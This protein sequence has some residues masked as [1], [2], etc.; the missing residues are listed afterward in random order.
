MHASLGCSQPHEITY[1]PAFVFRTITNYSEAINLDQSRSTRPMQSLE[2]EAS[3]PR[4]HL[5]YCNHKGQLLLSLRLHCL[6]WDQQNRQLNLLSR[7]IGPKGCPRPIHRPRAGADRWTSRDHTRD[8]EV[9][10]P[11]PARSQAIMKRPVTEAVMARDQKI[12]IAAIM[13]R[14]ASGITRNDKTSVSVQSPAAGNHDPHYPG[15]ELH[16][17]EGSTVPVHGLTRAS[18]IRPSNPQ[19]I[20]EFQIRWYRVQGSRPER[21]PGNHRRTNRRAAHS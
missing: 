10:N 6:L 8:Q 2:Q 12:P 15:A 18:P 9:M 13:I 17:R 7:I 19:G 1:L 16:Y 21:G 20:R 5:Q 3:R 14:S 11:G 4:P